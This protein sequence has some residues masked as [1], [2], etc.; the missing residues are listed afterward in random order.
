MLWTGVRMTSR[1]FILVCISLTCAFAQSIVAAHSGVIHFFEGVVTIDGQLLEQKVGRFDEIKEGSEL[2]T[3]Q[4]RAEVLL[5]P[6]VLL[7]VD[8]NTAIRMLSNK[9]SDTKIEFISG[10]ATLD[11]RNAAPGAPVHILFKDYKMRFARSGRYRFD[12]SPAQLRVDEGE[13]EVFLRDKA[14][15][16]KAGEEIALST[17]LA[18]RAAAN[19]SDDGLD[20]W[21]DDRKS[22]IAADNAADASSDNLSR[23]LNDP[24]N[25]SY[26]PGGGYAGGGYSGGG[27]VPDPVSSGYY[28]YSGYSPGSLYSP[29]G[30]YG[31]GFRFGYMPL[32]VRVPAYRSY[33]VRTGTFRVPTPIRSAP[34]R[35]SAPGRTAITPPVRNL[36]PRPVARPVIH[37]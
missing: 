16:A 21:D 23:A 19:R 13:A 30:F 2:K 5:T 7:R 25:N 6:G 24:Q 31:S 15:M 26:D 11:S 8:Q 20:R 37:R 1:W 35:S 22:A 17:A 32:F 34:V 36:A 3:G 12:S 9:L 28:G 29:F 27:L 33:P 4:G 14:V 10:A 18:V